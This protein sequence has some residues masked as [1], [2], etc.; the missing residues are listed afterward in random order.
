MLNLKVLFLTYAPSP[1]R[2]DFFNELGKLVDLTVCYEINKEE[3]KKKNGRNDLWHV[4]T[5]NNYKETYLKY[6]RIYKYSISYDVIKIIKKKCFDI[7]VIGGYNSLTAM[8]TM[9][10]LKKKKISFILSTDGGFPK[11]NENKI[12]YMVKRHF[13]SMADYYLSTGKN[14]NNYLT[15]YGAK[16]DNI[17]IYPFTSM[18]EKDVLKLPLSKLEKQKIKEKLKIDNKITFISVGR[19]MKIKGFDILIKS[20]KGLNNA[21]FII[22]GDK[23]NE[24]YLDL[25]KKLKI[26][27]IKIIDFK[28]KKEL[29]TYLKAADIFVLATRNDIWGLVIN[30]ALS[31]GLPV[32]TTNKC[33]AG[34]DLVRDDYNG[35][36]IEAENIKQLH[37]KMKIFIDEPKKIDEMGINAIESIKNYTIENEAKTHYEIFNKILNK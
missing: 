35:Y 37:D 31:N 15:Y 17:F 20:I 10:Y 21:Q 12:K 27:N 6:I 25:I 11:T 30:E 14:A 33:G 16:E 29:M 7:I 23:P 9:E 13:I 36:L 19:F 5:N 2:V 22:I 1:Y 24:E 3:D 26:T 32:I 8:I 18:G 4:K 28:Q 34:L